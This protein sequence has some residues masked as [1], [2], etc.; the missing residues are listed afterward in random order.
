MGVRKRVYWPTETPASKN[1]SAVSCS[2]AEVRR[3]LFDRAA[4]RGVWSDDE[5][6]AVGYNAIELKRKCN[7]TAAPI[8]AFGLLMSIRRAQPS[9]SLR[10][11]VLRPKAKKSEQA[12]R[13]CEGWCD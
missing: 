9:N 1:H 2:L 4:A 3:Q 12:S 5:G 6:A 8:D 10:C 13:E 11:S 7:R